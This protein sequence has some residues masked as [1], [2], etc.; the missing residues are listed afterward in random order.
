MSDRIKTDGT[1]ETKEGGRLFLK[2]P[3]G[4]YSSNQ[5]CDAIKRV[6]AEI[7]LEEDRLLRSKIDFK[8]ETQGG[9]TYRGNSKYKF[10]GFYE[11]NV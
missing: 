7:V 4:G 3:T 1:I 5:I 11:S 2:N 6:D 9:A 8:Y 10:I